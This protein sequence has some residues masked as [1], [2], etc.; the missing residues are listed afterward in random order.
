MYVAIIINIKLNSIGKL[1]N[2]KIC[3]RLLSYEKE[4]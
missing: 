1:A 4:D 2:W 3:I